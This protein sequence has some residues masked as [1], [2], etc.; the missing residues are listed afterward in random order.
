M[1][2]AIWV[3]AALVGVA[4]LAALAIPRRRRPQ[5]AT[6]TETEPLLEAA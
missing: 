6:V 4:A 5:E 3:G 2:P 1:N